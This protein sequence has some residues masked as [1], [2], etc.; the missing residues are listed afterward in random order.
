MQSTFIQNHILGNIIYDQCI[1][2]ACGQHQLIKTEMDIL[3]F[4][5]NNPQFDTAT[6]IVRH[7]HLSKSHVSKSIRSLEE[8]GFLKT[9]YHGKDRR[10]IHLKLC[11]TAEDA[12]LDGLRA[13]KRFA[14]ILLRDFSEDEL[15][16]FW[17]YLR[18]ITENLQSYLEQRQEES[19]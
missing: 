11:P 9:S 3:L 10:T 18:R 5:H 4:L 16:K 2:A 12:I 6:D 1:L 8:R 15:E 14:S 17:Q 19:K 7:R 13:Q